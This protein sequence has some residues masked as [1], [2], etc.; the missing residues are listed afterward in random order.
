MNKLD[1]AGPLER[2]SPRCR[3]IPLPDPF[4]PGVTSVFVLD[5]EAGFP[6][7]LLDTG[8]DMPES[9]AALRAGLD[10]L[11]V[12][13]ETVYGAV[14]SHTHLDHSGGLLRWRP[15]RLLAHENAVQEMRNLQPSSSRG[16]R[17]LRIMGVPEELVGGLAPEEEP[18]GGAPFTRTPV[19]DR[20]SGPE[21]PIPGS[22][23]WSWIL[24][25]GHA[26]GHLLV[27]HPEDS[28]L[29]VADQFLH[30]WKTPI[31]ISDPEEDSFGLYLDSLNLALRLEPQIVCSSHTRAIQPAIPFLADRRRVLSR[32]LDRTLEAVENG[33]TT[34]WEVVS[35]GGDRRPSGGL[36]IL[37]L[38]ERLAM[39]RHLAAD[40]ALVRQLQ[41]GEER[42]APA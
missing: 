7:W 6:P 5:S 36:L 28:V 19:S 12:T 9:E 33:S 35:S 20:V 30:R 23:G 4:V 22:G 18:V 34:A 3:R 13:P 27:F 15:A 16:R 42:F 37:Y 1:P 11:S 17:A 38:R 40:G 10:R 25:E 8:A 24:A 31:R 29:L 39:L 32:Q 14:L 2:I 21:G 26:P 41:D